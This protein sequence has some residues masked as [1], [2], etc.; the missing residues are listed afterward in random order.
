MIKLLNKIC[1]KTHKTL[2][3]A[4]IDEITESIFT[5]DLETGKPVKKDT[6]II[7]ARNYVTVEIQPNGD[8]VWDLRVEMKRGGG[9]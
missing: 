7:G 5:T 8:Q 1:T 6:Y 9:E 4:G 3:H 2:H